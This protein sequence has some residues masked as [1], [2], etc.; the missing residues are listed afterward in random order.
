MCV[1]PNPVYAFP[2][3]KI[4]IYLPI[5]ENNNSLFIM[6]KHRDHYSIIGLHDIDEQAELNYGIM[7]SIF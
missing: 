7:L 6:L 2:V 1:T 4:S 3:N 5:I